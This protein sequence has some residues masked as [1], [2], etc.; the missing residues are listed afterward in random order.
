MLL[1]EQVA[2][3]LVQALV[4]V[5]AFIVVRPW[6]VVSYMFLHAGFSHLFWNMV[7]LYFF[8][9]RLEARLGGRR[10][11]ALYF[12]SGIAGA[13]ASLVTPTAAIIGASGAIFG[14][15]L[16]YATFWPRDPIYLFFVL[17]IEARWLVLLMTM[18]ALYQGLAG[19]SG[20]ANFAHLGGFAGGWLYLRWLDLRSPAARFR[21]R[22]AAP[23]R[24]SGADVERWKRI[25]PDALHPVNREEY[26]RVMAKVALAGSASLTPDERAFLDRF[27]VQ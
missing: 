16:G 26:E 7:A 12:V 17:R 18:M 13:L 24:T 15:M 5:P 21:S 11:L 22:A 8:G 9:P 23:P 3:G 19:Q 20:I 6:T 10:F 1:I 27:S 2:P 14:V 25:R 4:L